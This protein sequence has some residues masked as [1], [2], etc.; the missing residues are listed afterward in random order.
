MRITELMVLVRERR[1]AISR[2]NS[3]ECFFGCS[4]NFS[5]SLSPRISS[6][7]T[8]IS[9]ACPFPSEATNSP[10]AEMHA[11]VVIRFVMASS[12]VSRLTTTC[13]VWMV[14]PSLRAINWLLRKVRTQP[15]AFT[16]WPFGSVASNSFI[17]IR[18]IIV[19]NSL[20]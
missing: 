12:K 15:C 1:W 14:E 8:F 20:R 13:I 3:S 11:P 19:D 6:S 18:F 7:F 10:V 4:G 17:L 9:T 5:A 16:I 2:R